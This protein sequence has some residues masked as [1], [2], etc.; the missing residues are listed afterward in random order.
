MKRND[1]RGYPLD[2]V[3]SFAEQTL[4]G[5]ACMSAACFWPSGSVR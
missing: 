4:R 3:R 1:H 5:V 2:F